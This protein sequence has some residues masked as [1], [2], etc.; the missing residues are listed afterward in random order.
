MNKKEF[1]MQLATN[2][3]LSKWMMEN[4]SWIKSKPEVMRYIVL[5]P[6]G[7][8]HF[9]AGHPVDNETISRNAQRFMSQMMEERANRKRGKVKSNEKVKLQPPPKEG[10]KR[11]GGL[12]GNL[13][14]MFPMFGSLPTAPAAPA[15]FPPTLRPPGMIPYA[16]PAGMT[17]QAAPKV[18][19]KRKS[20]LRLPKINI[21]RAKLMDT[22]SQTT[23]MLDV[24]SA[25]IGKL[26]SLK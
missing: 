18:K 13:K 5:H 21:S 23:E 7:M 16:R 17:T 25:L 14:S 2:P 12:F 22:M 1:K 11:I 6:N 26:G 15:A 9:R 19:V 4:M 8:Q 3:V 24:I 20:P 10:K